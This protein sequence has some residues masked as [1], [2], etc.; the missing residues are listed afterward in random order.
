[1]FI[2]YFKNI[3]TE[4]HIMT[5][6]HTLDSLIV[7]VI[8]VSSCYWSQVDTLCDPKSKLLNFTTLHLEVFALKSVKDTHV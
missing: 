7:K 2:R 1:V 4:Y 3:L 8:P 5:T 6:N